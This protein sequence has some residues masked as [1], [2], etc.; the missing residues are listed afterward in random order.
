MSIIRRITLA[1][2]ALALSGTAFAQY[3]NKPIKIIVPYP[4][5]GTSDILARAV[6]QKMS[7]EWKQPVVV[8]NK[9]GAT[10]NIGADF[11]AKSTDAGY[12]LL[13]A[14]IGS[15]AISPS[16]FP[17]LPFDPVKD[18][19]PVIMVAYSPHILA[20][21]PS[22]PA[23]NVKELVALAKAKPD[24]LNFAVSGLG[25]ANHLAGIDFAMRSGIKWTYIPY[26]GGSQALA[27][28]MGGQAQVMFNG[29]LATYPMVKDGK[30]KALAIS[31][32]KRFSAAPDLPTVAESGYPGFETGS[33][34]GIV[35]PANT[36]KEVVTALH[37]A[38]TKILATPEMKARLEGAGAEVRPM[39]PEQFGQFI[40][41]EK[42]RWAKV[43]KESGAKFD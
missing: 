35:A 10:G 36:P 39:S 7:E 22:V 15:L 5:G 11:V 16:V 1:L 17:T 43:I 2:A 20:A 29:M 14:D 6:G 41:S 33:F 19:A 34:Q 9:P 12:T 30:L 21:H 18:F 27:D 23:N 42:A 25:G 24:S 37:A 3:P 26:K 38:I 40:A 31:S 32:E 4:P 13:L 8:E 28:L